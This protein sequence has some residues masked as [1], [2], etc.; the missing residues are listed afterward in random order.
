MPPPIRWRMVPASLRLSIATTCAVLAAMVGA[1]SSIAQTPSISRN[2]ITIPFLAN[3]SKPTDL[4]FESAECEIEA[5]GSRMTCEFQ[6]VFLTTTPVTP[7][8]CLVTTNRYD[9]EFRRDSPNR[10][11]N[12]EG[13][14]GACGLLDVVALTSEG[15]AKWTMELKKEVTRKEGSAACQTMKPETEVFSWQNIRRP[16]PCRNVQPGALNP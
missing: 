5:G 2:H 12:R 14:E 16:L 7:D 1:Q 15:G 8:T 11:I 6:Q 10:W 13:P 9:R 3:A 4:E